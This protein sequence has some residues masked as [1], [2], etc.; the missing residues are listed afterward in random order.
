[1]Q[2]QFWILLLAI[3]CFAGWHVLSKFDACLM[4]VLSI[5]LFSF[6]NCFLY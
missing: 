4:F 1:L 2:I 5:E 3:W 6:K